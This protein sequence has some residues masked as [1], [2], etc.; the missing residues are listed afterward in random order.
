MTPRKYEWPKP[1]AI[2]SNCVPLKAVFTEEYSTHRSA[3]VKYPN[4]R[5]VGLDLPPNNMEIAMQDY[6][7][8]LLDAA[9]EEFED[10][11]WADDYSDV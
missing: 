5:T 9:F 2:L 10:D 3:K 7:E 1:Q 11:D 4:D 8:E 6:V